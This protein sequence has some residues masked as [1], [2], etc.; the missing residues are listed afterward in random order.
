M[1]LLPE[2]EYTRP[3]TADYME[4]DDDNKDGEVE[5]DG[6]ADKNDSEG[7]VDVETGPKTLAITGHHSEDENDIRTRTGGNDAIQVQMGSDEDDAAV[8][9]NNGNEIESG[10][11]INNNNGD[12]AV[13][14]DPAVEIQQAPVDPPGQMAADQEVPTDAV[15]PPLP[16]FHSNTLYTATTSTTC[17]IC[18]DEF[19]EGEQIRLL[20]RCGHGYHTDCIL[21][22]L[23][24][25]QGCCP[26]CKT[27]ALPPPNEE[28]GAAKEEG[29]NEP[30]EQSTSPAVEP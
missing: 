19:E 11:D 5:D 24:E 9:E 12:G 16:N 20:P 22:W 15:P 23:T 1:E 13:T 21:P 6:N 7:D 17:S 18:I 27:P 25:R 14:T 30:Q 4:E 28:D 2:I 8:K 29:E 10:A 26:F 3:A